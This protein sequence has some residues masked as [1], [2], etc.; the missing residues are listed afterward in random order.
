MDDF[1]QLYNVLIDGIPA[2]RSVIGALSGD[3]WTAVETADTFGMAMT[4]PCDTIPPQ[5]PAPC[6]GMDL[7]DLA[8][9]SKSWNLTEAS[10]GVAAINAFYNTPQRL[11]TLQA[12]LEFDLYCTR[13]LDLKGKRIGVVGHLNMP[14]FVRDQA[15]ELLILERNPRPGDYPD[16]ACEWIL[17]TCDIVLITG[18]TLVNKTLP[19][20]LQLCGSAYTILTGPTVPLC[21]ALLEMGI[22]RIAGLVITDRPGM[23]HTIQNNLPGPLYPYGRSFLLS[24]DH[25]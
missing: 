20:L 3:Q 4:T 17:P 18:S 23:T 11:D 14:D 10:Y 5:F 12:D 8:Q 25:L 9:A 2:G 16:T 1:F 7:R 21:P 13:G 22:D 6:A 24:R 19:R 15:A